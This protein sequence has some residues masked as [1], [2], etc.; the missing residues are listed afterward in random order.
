MHC[1]VEVRQVRS[2]QYKYR[3]RICNFLTN[4]RKIYNTS[5]LLPEDLQITIRPKNFKDN[6]CTANQV[7]NDFNIRKDAIKG[8][9]LYLRRHYSAYQPDVL[10]ISDGNL[11]AFEEEPF[12]DDEVIVHEI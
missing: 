6:E 10:M 1:F 8:W 3:G 11:D 9:L 4:T 12:V 5:P 7:R 2:Q